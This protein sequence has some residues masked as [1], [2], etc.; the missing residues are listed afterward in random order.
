MTLVRWKPNRNWMHNPNVVDRF[1]DD[2]FTNSSFE[3]DTVWN[4]SIDIVEKDDKLF[5]TVELPG[6]NKDD[7]KILIENNILSIEGTK[8][9]EEEKNEHYYRIERSFGSFKRSFKLPFQVDSKKIKAN[10]KDGLVKIEIPKSLE[11]KAKE[12]QI[13][14]E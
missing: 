6:I 10:F 2:F 8:K 13:S 9:Q 3:S 12:I 14:F 1:F 11:A 7:V 4:P 5:A